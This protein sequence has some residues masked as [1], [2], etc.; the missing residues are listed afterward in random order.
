MERSTDRHSVHRAIARVLLFTFSVNTLSLA[1]QT[2]P[3]ASAQT[4]APR[5]TAQAVTTTAADDIAIYGPQKFVR[6]NG[7]KDVYTLDI[8]FPL[9][10]DSPYRLRVINGE[11]NGSF[12]V[13]SATI[14]VNGV[15]ICK[16]SDF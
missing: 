3:P 7:P 6:T 12:R 11:A 13:S 5:L 2:P 1:A 4:T 16:Q 14:E 15:L 8:T 9:W 10:A